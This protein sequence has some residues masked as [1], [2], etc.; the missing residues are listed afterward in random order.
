MKTRFIRGTF[1]DFIDDPWKHVGKEEESARFY[2]DGLMVMDNGV[3]K[4]FGPSVANTSA[5][6]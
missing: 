3:I 5:N 2:A 6:R 1:F 4:A